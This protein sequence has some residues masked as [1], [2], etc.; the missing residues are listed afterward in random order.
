MRGGTVASCIFQ[1]S[2]GLR[3]TY[4]GSWSASGLETPWFGDW[5]IDG[6]LGAARWRD[7]G[8][9]V[10]EPGG[11]VIDAGG[12]NDHPAAVPALLTQM[13]G[14]GPLETP[15]ADNIR[16]LAMV[17]AAIESARTGRWVG[18]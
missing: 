7:D 17:P 16:S 14:G 8:S 12:P 10:I 11:R 2:G 4:R 15:A 1:F 3:F 13:A 6:T 5:R 18:L 9:P